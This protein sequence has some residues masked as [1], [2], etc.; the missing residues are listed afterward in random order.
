MLVW[1][2]SMFSVELWL[3]LCTSTWMVE[4]L[5][6]GILCVT[7]PRSVNLGSSKEEEVSK[8]LQ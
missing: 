1:L 2:Q 5:F 3:P 7:D 6:V 4:S 8:C